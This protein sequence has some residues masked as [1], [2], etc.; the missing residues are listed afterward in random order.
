[1]GW[2]WGIECLSC[3]SKK[4]CKTVG[5][6]NVLDIFIRRSIAHEHEIQLPEYQGMRDSVGIQLETRF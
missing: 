1:M 5:A 3:I 4:L 6:L 2:R